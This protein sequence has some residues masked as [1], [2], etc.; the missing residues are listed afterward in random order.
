MAPV[1]D[2][3]APALL[4]VWSYCVL[5]DTAFANFTLDNEFHSS[6]IHRR[7]KSQERREMQRE[8]LSILGLPH[9]PR[10]HLHG[11][12]NAAPMFMLDLYN[13]MS[14]EGD[15]DRYS[16]PYKPVFTTQGPPIASLQ[17]NNFLNDADMVM[18]FVNLVE[19]DKEFLPVRRHHREFRFDLSRIPEGEAVTAAEFRIYKDF[20]HERYDNET[21]RISVYQVLE[22]HSDRESDLFLLDSRAIWAAEEGWLVFDVTAT[23]NHWVLNPGRNLGLQLAL[24]STNGESI[25]PR[26]A[27]LIGRTGPQN[28]QPFM[29]AFFKA[30]EVH[31]RSIRSAPAGAKQRNPNRSKGAKS[32]EAL[33]VASVAE[34]SS[35]DQKQACKKHEL[36]VSF[37]DLGWQDWIIAPEGYAAYYCEGECAFPLNSYMN[38][39]NHAIVQTLVHFINPDTVPKP[40]C[41]PTQLH[42]I[43]VLYFDDSSN[44]WAEYKGK[45]RE[46]RDKADPTMWKTRLRCALNK[47]TDFLEV[48]ERNQL[49]ITEPYKVYRIQEHGSARPVESPQ[50]NDRGIVLAKVS[51]KIL[52]DKQGQRVMEVTTR[53]PDGC[54]ILQGRVPLGSERIYG[55]CSAQQLSFPSPG[56][57]S[58]PSC[59]TDAMNRLLCHLERGVLLWV[60]HD[61]VFIKRFCQG[62][63]YWSGPTAQHTDRPNK[64]EREK[65]FKLLDVPEFSSSKETSAYSSLKRCSLSVNGALGE[66]QLGGDGGDGGD[67]VDSQL[68]HSGREGVGG[69]TLHEGDHEQYSNPPFPPTSVT[70]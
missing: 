57:L 67:A 27:G 56:S 39:T 38:A 58:L 69:A 55:P 5:A 3:R 51:P 54:F 15:E 43:S 42:A 26:V 17:D 47:S 49:D 1:L 35:T 22:E 29:V 6:F 23:S 11:K 28:K 63:V 50:M 66:V 44:A 48:P 10:P 2:R 40:C 31:L 45:Y 9:R 4:L 25:N 65:T 19:H 36:Y 20:I 59:M 33:R 16:Y 18:S 12:H 21:F 46:G 13:A 70:F 64:L 8:I 34:N 41:A 53:S 52:L 60:A 24:E 14:T 32:Q 7:L 62:R 30:T 68:Q 37:R 61:G